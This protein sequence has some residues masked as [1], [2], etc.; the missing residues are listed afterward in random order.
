[1]GA[2]DLLLPLRPP[3]GFNLALAALACLL[4][5]LGFN[6]PPNTVTDQSPQSHL[7]LGTGNFID[8]HP[9]TIVPGG[10]G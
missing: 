7:I 2:A 8:S 6:G 5:S 1:M 3:R 9:L 10:I 4:L